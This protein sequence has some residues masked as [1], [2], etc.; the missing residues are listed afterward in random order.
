[1]IVHI[2]DRDRSVADAI[3]SVVEAEGLTAVVYDTIAKLS[4]PD[5][6]ADRDLVFI[7]DYLPDMPD[8][9]FA[10]AVYRLPRSARF[11]FISNGRPVLSDSVKSAIGIDPP[12][13]RKPFHPCQL[14]DSIRA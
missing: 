6:V 3:A 12:V 4:E 10:E 9:A 7:C 5:R 2:L 11:V 14:M 8:D 1:M 13:L